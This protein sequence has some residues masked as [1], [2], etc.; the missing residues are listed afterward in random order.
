M[1]T[2]IL[3]IF[4]FLNFA[5]R[6]GV[7]DTVRT[8]PVNA[9]MLAAQD[10]YNRIKTQDSVFAI[11]S[12]RQLI[13]I[14]YDLDDMSLRCFATSLM[15]DQYARIR[16]FNNESTQL[17]EQAI[18]MARENSLELME[19]I[20][21]FRMGRYY[22]NF[23]KY[24]PAFEY[25]IRAD[26]YF[27]NRAYRDVPNVDEILHFMA[28][29]YYETGNDEM[30]EQYLKDILQLPKTGAYI[31]KQTLNTLALISRQRNNNEKSLDYF[32]QTLQE[33]MSEQ[34][35]VWMGISYTNIAMILHIQEKYDSAYQLFRKGYDLSHRYKEWT[36]AFICLLS[37]A[38][39]DMHR[40]NMD[41]ADKKIQEAGASL[42]GSAALNTR[43][44]WYETLVVFYKAK[45]QP[46]LALEAQNRLIAVKDS[47]TI[48]KDQKA[49]RDIQLRIEMEKHMNEIG[50]LEAEKRA[51]A[52]K[53]NGIII[54]MALLIL[55]L[56]LW[57]WSY[58]IKVRSNA[59]I[60][61][62]DKMRAEEK[63]K[64][65]RQLLQNFTENTRQKNELIVQFADEL[66]K[67]K[68]GMPAHTMYGSK[69]L[70]V[71]KLMQSNILSDEEWE[72]FRELFDK[73]H[74]GFFQRL[75]EKFP[76]L[77]INETRMVTLMRLGISEREMSN[78]MGVS[79]E[80]IS[81]IKKG[82]RS[83]MEMA[84][85]PVAEEI[86]KNI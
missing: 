38:K 59:A 57:Y 62:A 84:N 32:R 41:M 45:K 5:G 64:Y 82:L 9:R 49:Y 27:K 67:L 31:K 24:P 51:D 43:K 69:L 13:D 4:L 8:V 55:V 80:K 61:Q 36:H 56:L 18:R 26:N 1:R 65:A 44:L 73:V 71:E 66:E 47:I 10:V 39:I 20:C 11:A 3:S 76:G 33:A 52:L 77:S 85:D 28:G 23:K 48:S 14:T 53:R 46:D 17:H 40:G 63:L 34:D 21:T 74:K 19:A 37:M 81:E 50:T 29:I 75:S 86:I 79:A 60:L 58:R 78:M 42:S 6:A 30:A 54:V 7:F 35:S 72:S 16:S 15:A 2:V 70:Q 83:K 12:I 22:Y 25:L 68:A